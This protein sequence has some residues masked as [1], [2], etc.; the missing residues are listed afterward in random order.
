MIFYP[1]HN[2]M[3]VRDIGLWKGKDGKYILPFRFLR[4]DR[5]SLDSE[6]ILPFLESHEI[7]DVIDLRTDRVIKRFPSCLLES[8]L[9]YHHIPIEEGSTISIQSMPVEEL[10]SRMIEHKDT[11]YQ[12]FHTIAHAQKGVLIHC[13]AGKDRTGIVVALLEEILG[14][15][16][17]DIILDYSFSSYILAITSQEYQKTHPQF[18]PFVGESKEEYMKNFL[19]GFHKKYGSAY[20]YLLH[21]GITEEEI[22]KIERKAYGS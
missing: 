22:L 19:D 10:Y 14:M 20:A 4:S 13:T 11:F 18:S 6:E 15:S 7:S 16:E 5:P 17:E 21:I 8:S 3:N 1:I 12:I 9:N 2:M